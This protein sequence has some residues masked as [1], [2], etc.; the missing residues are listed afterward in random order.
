MKGCITGWNDE[1]GFGFVISEDDEADRIFAHISNF[2]KGSPRP[3][4]G[5]RVEF[6][7][8]SNGERGLQAVQIQLIRSPLEWSRAETINLLISVGALAAIGIYGVVTGIP[9]M[10]NIAILLGYTILSLI[11]YVIFADDKRRA[12]TGKW[13]WEERQLHMLSLFGG[14]PGALV[15]QRKLRHKNRK[16][17]FQVTM[18][19]M[20]L[21]NVTVVITVYTFLPEMTSYVSANSRHVDQQPDEHAL[22]VIRPRR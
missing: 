15:A 21:L 8:E 2:V 6:A 1:R 18:L 5:D 4:D 19:A 17:A 16:V 3:R 13:R 22:P 14:W 20:I 12:Q 11:T 10:M 7:I 9:S